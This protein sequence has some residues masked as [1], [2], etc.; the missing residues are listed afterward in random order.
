MYYITLILCINRDVLAI[1]PDQWPVIVIGLLAG[2]LGSVMDSLLGATLQYS[3]MNMRTL[4]IVESPGNNVRWISGLHLL[5]NHSVNLL[6]ALAM[7]LIIP[8]ISQ[9]FWA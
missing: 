3:G 5:D 7:A 9:I 2:F 6:S 1:S 4:K 8:R